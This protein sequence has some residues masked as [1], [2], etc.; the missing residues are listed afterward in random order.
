MLF[1]FFSEELFLVADIL[2]Q[3][4]HKAILAA[5]KILHLF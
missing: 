3:K 1:L 4:V 2:L 5:L